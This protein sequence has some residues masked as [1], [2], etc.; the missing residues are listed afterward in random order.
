MRPSKLPQV[1]TSIFSQMSALAA[2]HGAINLSQGFPNFPIDQSLVDELVSQAKNDVHQYTPMQGLPALRAEVCSLIALKYQRTCA[3][4]DVLVTAG[5]TQAIFT[6]IQA[7]V[8]PGDEVIILDPSYDCYEAPVVLSNARPVRIPLQAD[9]RPNWDL[10]ASCI[11]PK[12]RLLITNNP[13][14]PSG[15]IW[16]ASDYDQLEQLMAQHPQLLL[17]SDEVYEHIVFA[18]H[19]SI[20]QRPLLHERSMIVSSFGKTFHITGWKIGYVVA[21]PK[22]MHELLKVHQY[23]VFCV[24]SVAQ[25]T[26]ANYMKQVDVSRLGPF[27]QQK[28]DVFASALESSR[29]ELLPTQGSYFQLASYA[30]ISAKSDLEF[31]EELTI[32]HGVAAIPLSVFNAN[33]EDRHLIRFC[34]AKTDET[35]YLASERLC[36]I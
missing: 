1:G 17:L 25:H 36:K 11:G 14:N 26:L 10:I 21:P 8:H 30:R 33:G 24:N 16:E 35:L 18:P 22:L 19:Q 5:A 7:L 9:F 6:C 23:L 20:H 34:F 15:R 31:C 13:H 2:A 28:R 29:F 12:T 3:I 32:K 27:Y 4:E